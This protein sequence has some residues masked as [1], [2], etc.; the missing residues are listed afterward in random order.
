MVP[1]IRT[2][3]A[4]AFVPRRRFTI[5]E[6]HRMGE[7]GVLAEDDR[8]ELLDGEILQMT[9]IGVPHASCVD[10]LNALFTRRLRDRAIVRVQ[11]PIILNRWSEPQPDLALLAARP[12][13]Y[14]SAHPRP[15]DVLLAIEV[16]DTSRGYDR[17]LKLPLYARAELREVWLLDVVARVLE[18]HRRPALRGYRQ[19]QRLVAGQAV[20]PL[21]FPRLR[22]RV[23]ELL[24]KR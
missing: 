23:N 12:D 22:F 17:T 8:V 18:V 13:F 9:P 5:D 14:A 20:A 16:M 2:Q 3:A 7:A 24:G 21:A 6:Y 11:N 1:R 10:R 15:R 19:E 4:A